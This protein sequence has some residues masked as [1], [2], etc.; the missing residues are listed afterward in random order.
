M[1]KAS[2]RKADELAAPAPVCNPLRDRALLEA[3]TRELAAAIV[4]QK[5]KMT[6]MAFCVEVLRSLKLHDIAIGQA[7]RIIPT[8]RHAGKSLLAE[9]GIMIPASAIVSVVCTS[10]PT[11]FATGT[12]AAPSSCS[13]AMIPFMSVSNSV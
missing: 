12:P 1:G 5:R 8:F 7:E 13:A 3:A 11:G 2:K 6:A 4:K 10:V 9:A